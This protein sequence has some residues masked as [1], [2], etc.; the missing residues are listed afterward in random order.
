MGDVTPRSLTGCA[1]I[2]AVAHIKVSRRRE[3]KN[4][5]KERREK[6]E[7]ERHNSIFHYI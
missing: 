2:D 1:G 7:R 3:N 6:E 4:A 5:K